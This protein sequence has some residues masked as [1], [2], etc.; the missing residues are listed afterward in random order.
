MAVFPPL[1]GGNED[2]ICLRSNE[3]R[4]KLLLPKAMALTKAADE[5]I[6]PFA[7]LSSAPSSLSAPCVSEFKKTYADCSTVM[8]LGR[9]NATLRNPV[10]VGEFEF[11]VVIVLSVDQ[12]RQPFLLPLVGEL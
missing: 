1:D 10:L 7:M 8:L 5:S 4:R 9:E 12:R 6:L 2:L 3:K 11:P